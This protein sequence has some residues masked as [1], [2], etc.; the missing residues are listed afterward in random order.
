MHC[1]TCGMKVLEQAVVCLNCGCLPLLG[2]KF[3]QQCGFETN[4]AASGCSKC[5][6]P[7]R[8]NSS[9]S[10]LGIR[11][12]S[13]ATTPNP[14]ATKPPLSTQVVGLAMFLFFPV[15]LY[16]LWKHPVLGRNKTWWWVGGVWSFLVLMAAMN[17]DKDK[18]PTKNE[19]PVAEFERETAP[20]NPAVKFRDVSTK[21]K[22][23]PVRQASAD[24]SGSSS[25]KHNGGVFKS[26]WDYKNGCQVIYDGTV[27]KTQARK[28][29]DYLERQGWFDQDTKTF[30]L[31]KSG[32]TYEFRMVIKKGLEQDP[33][34][35]EGMKVVALMLSQ[36]VFDGAEADVHLCD[37]HMKTLRVVVP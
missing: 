37:E 32:K 6:A 15:G 24:G 20:T 13:V 7:L 9:T 1:R 36:E 19:P 33:E 16:L 8:T 17:G 3:C 27:S 28:V 10:R 2:D 11:S 29:G 25:A 18:G 5:G 21:G 4:A 23:E 30:Q 34:V 31:G 35:I 26:S 14:Q 12:G 22:R